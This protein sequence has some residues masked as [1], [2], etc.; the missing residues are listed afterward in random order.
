MVNTGSVSPAGQGP[1]SRRAEQTRAPRQ[2]TTPGRVGPILRPEL[3]AQVVEVPG[4]NFKVMLR[5]VGVGL[6][7]W[8]SLSRAISCVTVG[9][10]REQLGGEPGAAVK[11]LN[12][13]D[14]REI[15]TALS[16]ATG[17]T[18]R[19][20]TM[21]EW[22]EIR[23]VLGTVDREPWET[24][25]VWVEGNYHGNTELNYLRHLNVDDARH[26]TGQ[27]RTFRSPTERDVLSTV[28]LIVEN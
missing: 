12:L 1:K 3:S 15:A 21:E 27:D 16:A 4:T 22:E 23:L 10:V 6:L 11:Y 17:K 18:W 2:A 8:L 5:E 14:A 7:N 28:R 25:W 9:E 19:V 13:L 24:G 20:P 26:K